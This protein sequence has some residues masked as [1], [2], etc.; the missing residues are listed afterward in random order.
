MALWG[1]ND[2]KTSAG[3]VTLHANG[4]VVGSS[5]V[6]ADQAA[7][8]DFLVID[9]T[10]AHYLITAIT[11]N[12]IAT[13]V[14]GTPGGSITAV[15]AGNAYSLTEKPIYVAT[16]DATQFGEGAANVYG[17]NAAEIAVTNGPQHAGWVKRM[18][19]TGAGGTGTRVRYET[20][21]ANSGITSDAADD[22]QFP[23][24]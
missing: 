1:V 18:V 8:G 11:S 12:T 24:T 23:D 20:L 5:T 6:F 22:T 2:D 10:N 9:A 19:S 16:A 15:A 21:V 3:T 17:V 14:A 7:V 13:V 4:Q